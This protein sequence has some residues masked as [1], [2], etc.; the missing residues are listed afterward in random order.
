[1]KYFFLFLFITISISGCQSIDY[2]QE[3]EK[4]KKLMKD[5]EDCWNNGDLECFMKSYWKSNE[6]VFIG[7]SGPK[8]GWIT[9]LENY[10]KSYPD[11]RAMGTLTFD[12]ISIDITSQKSAFVIGKWNL[13]RA[14]GNLSG[15]YTLLWKQINEQWVIVADHSS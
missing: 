9:T 2:N 6:L 8:Y 1:M 14:D 11:K 3:S 13:D 7:K 4:I 15:H 5:Q 10:Q 12:I